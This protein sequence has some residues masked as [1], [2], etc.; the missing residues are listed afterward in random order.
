[1]SSFYVAMGFI[2][3]LALVG[4]FVVLRGLRQIEKE[5]AANAREQTTAK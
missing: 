3:T 5:D 2:L 1:M 4:S